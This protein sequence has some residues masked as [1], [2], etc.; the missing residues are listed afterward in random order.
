MTDSQPVSSSTQSPAPGRPKPRWL[1]LIILALLMTLI[2]LVCTLAAM[3]ARY[4]WTL[5]LFT[6]WKAHTAGGLLIPLVILLVL[7]RWKLAGIPLVLLL[8]N[9]L[10]VA[11]LYLPASTPEVSSP[12]QVK[13]L[14]ANV[15][16]QNKTPELFIDLVRQQLPDVIAVLELHPNWVEPLQAIHVRYPYHMIVPRHDSFGIAVF[17]RHPIL[18]QQQLILAQSQVPTLDITLDIEGRPIQVIA[19]HPLPP[20]SF[21]YTATRNAHLQELATHVRT[22]DKPVIVLG[23][24]NTTPWSPSFKDLLAQS[25]LKNSQQGH[26]IDASWPAG[27]GLMRIPIDHILVSDTIKVTRRRLGPAIGSDHLPVL[28]TV[29]IP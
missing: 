29:E 2:G 15:H 9:A 13:L 27:G 1:L 7:R 8:I 4:H 11:S 3:G 20:M 18:H 19:T 24:L 10:P 26:G 6:H 12:T 25:G 28:A 17:S 21:H 16:N 22:I 5:D 23:D 14:L